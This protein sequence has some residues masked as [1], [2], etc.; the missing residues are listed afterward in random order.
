MKRL[1]FFLGLYFIQLCSCSN[2]L[3]APSYEKGNSPFLETDLLAGML[4]VKSAGTTVLLG[5]SDALAKIIDRPQMTVRLSYDFSIGRTEVTCAEFNSLMPE[6]TGLALDC[7]DGNLP[8]TDVTYY[9]AVLFANERGKAEGLDTAYTYTSASLDAE[10]HCTNLEGF[11]YR[12]GVAAYRLPTEAEWVLVAGAYW[13]GAKAW[14]AENSAYRL[15]GVCS[16]DTAQTVCDMMGN[17][18]EWVNDWLGRFHDTTL[19]NYVG[20]PDGGALGQRVVKGGSYRNAASSITLYGRGDVYT[21]TSSTRAGYVGFRLAFGA[22]PDAVWMGNGGRAQSSRTV[23]LASSATVRTVL[24]TRKAKL[25]YRNDLT[26]NLSVIDYSNGN[27]SV[28]EYDDTLEVYH[29]EI[30]PDGRRVAF[31]TG[32]E[33]V[34]GKSSL[35]VRD[36]DAA[37]SVPVKLDVESAAIPRWRVLEDGDTVIVYV[38][39]AG[40]NSEE[41]AFRDASTWQVKYAGGKFG[42]P[43]KLFDGAYHGGISSDGRLAV[44]GAR[45]LRARMA[46]EG[47][48]VVHDGRDTVWYGGEQAC[49]VSLSKDSSRRTLFLDFGGKTGRE[50]VGYDYGTHERLLVADSTGNLVQ[51]V[52]APARYSFDHSEWASSGNFAVAT[53]T[54]VNGSHTEIVLVDLFDS[55]VV[56]LVEGD[57]L[58]HPCLWMKPGKKEDENIALDA[59][60]AGIY[61]NDGDDWGTALMRYN[62]ELL[63][64][65]RDSADVVV[66]GSSRPFYSLLPSLMNERF[67]MVNFAQTPNSIHMS[68]DFLESYLFPH[69][70]KLKYV[71]LSLDIDFWSKADG[72]KSDNWFK[73]GYRKY[74]GYVYDKNHNYWRDGYPEGL[75]EYTKSYLDVEPYLLFEVDR[76]AIFQMFCGGWSDTPSIEVDSTACDSEKELYEN[77]FEALVDIVKSAANWNIVVIGVVFPQNPAYRNTGAFGRYGLRRSVAEQYISRFEELEV[78]Y[79]NFKFLDENKMGYHGYAKEMFVDDDHLCIE[80]AKFITATVDS[81]LMSLN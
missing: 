36:L 67:F 23:P 5:S 56:E 1:A 3:D 33:G 12:P 18:M 75:L 22:I 11:A 10:N 49:N 17:A 41:S 79:P 70:K 14:T 50:F 58:W 20:A 59:D 25:A 71:V 28:D 19:T 35:Y 13:K 74:P 77:S 30:S 9:D 15:H 6:A 81:L 40:N 54:N 34:A 72:E 2:S 45:I 66:V 80:G 65:Y 61:M 38:T 57:E 37:G 43:E 44:T 47:S 69:L 29:P 46:S 8:A 7:D 39:D 52:E 53:L 60:S 32:L 27:L 21:V 24:G 63:W 62:M 76:G 64:Q 42:T 31:C 48:T 4:R 26:G 78:Q 68:R 51:S 16:K 73:N 55:A